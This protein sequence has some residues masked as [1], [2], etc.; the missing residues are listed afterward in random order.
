MPDRESETRQCPFC[1]EEVKAAAVRCMHC[2]A[3][4]QPTKPDHEGV[5]PFCKEEINV[6]AIRCRHCKADLAPSGRRL[7]RVPR[8]QMAAPTAFISRGVRPRQTLGPQTL[9]PQTLRPSSAD[10]GCA[11]FDVDEAGTWCFLESSEHFCIYELC[12]PAPAPPYGIFE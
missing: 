6:E 1:K 9:G 11:D 5:C 7:R 8:R 12:D 2:L 4:I 10:P 3:A